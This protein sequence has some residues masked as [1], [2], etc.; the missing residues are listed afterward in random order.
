MTAKTEYSFQMTDQEI[1]DYYDSH[2]DV[3][4]TQLAKM[5][6]KSSRYVKELLLKG[7]EYTP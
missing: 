3:T 1:L 7:K 6:G 4:I 2:L 5:T